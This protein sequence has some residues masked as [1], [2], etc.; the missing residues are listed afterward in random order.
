VT[1]DGQTIVAPLPEGIK[2]HFGPDLRRFVLMQ[3]HQGQTTLPGLRA[4]LRAGHSDYVL[5]EAAFGYLR[6]RGMAAPLIARLAQADETHFVDQ[7]AW[8]A[9]LNQLGI[10][11][12]VKAGL[13]VIQEPADRFAW[14]PSASRPDPVL[15][16]TKGA[17]WGSIHAHGFMQ[18][19]VVLSDDAGQFDIGQH[20]LCWVHAERLVHKLD[21]FTDLQRAAQQCIRTLIWNFYAGLK[22]YRANPSK[23][24]RLALRARFD[25][26]FRRRTGFVTLVRLLKRLHA[27][28]AEL[29]MVLERPKIPLHTNGS[30]NDIRC[31]VTRRKLSAGTRSD[32]G[33][34]CRDAFLSLAKTCA[35]HGVA[36]WD[37]LGSRLGVPDQRSIPPLPQ[38]VRCRGQPA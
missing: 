25:R 20:G 6:S 35:T 10:V 29:L 8:Q 34:D 24:R 23:T 15:I 38:L 33:R 4:L 32:G 27:N 19:A 31:Q 11:S 28:K 9:H 21:T 36:F 16:A 26:I 7:A 18:D 14:H 37:Y 5:N 2:G 1:P 17:L 12:P 3:Y 30:E 22:V 13:A